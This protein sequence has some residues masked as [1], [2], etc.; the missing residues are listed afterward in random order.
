M[1]DRLDDSR[2]DNRGNEVRSIT[3]RTPKQR[4]TPERTAEIRLRILERAYDSPQIAATIARRLL[5]KGD[6]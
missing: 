3:S 2:G 5:Q 4:L 1:T 6:L